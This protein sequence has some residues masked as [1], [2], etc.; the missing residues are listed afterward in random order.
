MSRA[1]GVSVTTEQ[2]ATAD[3]NASPAAVVVAYRDPIVGQA[4]VRQLQTT[5]YEIRLVAE[6]SLVDSIEA[7]PMLAGCKL[8]LFTPGMSPGNRQNILEMLKSVPEAAD[9]PILE[10]GTPLEQTRPGIDFSMPWPSRSE[11]LKRQIEVILQGRT[12]PPAQNHQQNQ[13]ADL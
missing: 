2:I 1:I 4:V 13:E 9:M 6:S 12:D 8:I 7:P 3:H 11:D 5:P 10:L